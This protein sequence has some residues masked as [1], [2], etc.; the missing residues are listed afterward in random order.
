M[1]AAFFEKRRNECHMAVFLCHSLPMNDTKWQFSGG[2]KVSVG[3]PKSAKVSSEIWVVFMDV[4]EVSDRGN[5][6][7]RSGESLPVHVGKGGYSYVD[8]PWNRGTRSVAVHLLVALAFLGS[9]NRGVRHINGVRSDNRL[10]NLEYSHRTTRVTTPSHSPQRLHKPSS[11]VLAKFWGLL[12][13]G[14]KAASIVSAMG[15]PATT[16]YRWIRLIKRGK[17]PK[18][19]KDPRRD[20][21]GCKDG[22]KCGCHCH[23]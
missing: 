10:L 15:L 12:S 2:E 14:F 3:T 23:R 9:S 11:K 8:V 5:V 6:R 1:N 20:F 13:K 17:T 19:L 22:A 18:H 4:F 7:L 16:V 21:K